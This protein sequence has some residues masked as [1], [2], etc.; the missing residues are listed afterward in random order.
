MVALARSC[1]RVLAPAAVPLTEVVPPLAD[2]HPAFW[3]R[4]EETSAVM[5]GK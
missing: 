3:L 2:R 5:V 4:V 1:V